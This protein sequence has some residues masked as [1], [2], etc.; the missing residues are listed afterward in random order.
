[1]MG[2][3]LAVGLLAGACSGSDE[4]ASP[5][6][7]TPGV[8]V[9]EPGSEYVATIRRTSFGIPHIVAADYA[10]LGFGQG[11]ALAEDHACTLADQ[12]VKVRGERS[13]FFGA[14]TDDANLESDLAY[15]SLD[16]VGR[17]GAILPTLD[18][19]VVDAITGYAAG[20]DAWLAEVGV[21]GVPGWCQGEDWVR[22]ITPAELFAYLKDL[23]LLASSRNLITPI[24]T[25]APPA[26]AP[27]TPDLT[28]VPA[29]FGGAPDPAT[30]GSNGWAIGAEGTGTD[31]GMLVANPHFP[32]EGE[33]RLWEN[34]LTIP[35]RLDVYGAS[36]IGT[37]GVLIGFNENVAWTHT[38][39]AGARFT[40]Y[41][42]DLVPG[43]P[44]S[45]R[46]GAETRKMTST[47]ISVP[48]R[49][50]DGTTTDVT[51][52]MWSS[53]YGPMINFP[54]VG[55]TDTLALTYR[56]AALGDDGF[57][58]QFLE[59]DRAESLD[60][61]QAAFSE[62]DGTPWVNTMAVGA[63]GTA[64]YAD[65]SATP[66]LSP[67]A[68]AAYVASLETDALVGAAA[69]QRAVLLDGSDPMFEWVDVPGAPGPG[70]T[71]FDQ[72]PSLERADFVANANDP[73]WIANPAE[74]LTGAS[75]LYG[76]TDKPLSARTRENFIV[77]EELTGGAGRVDVEGAEQ[78]GAGEGGSI[79]TF[80]A[81]RHAVLANRSSTATLLQEA[82]AERCTAQP[83][84]RVPALVDDGGAEVWPAQ[85]VDL[86]DA[87]AVL[88]GW[89]GTFDLESIGAALWREFLA[90]FTP[91][92]RADAGIL[93]ANPFDP[94]DPIATPNGLADSATAEDGS[95]PVLVRLG[96]AVL[97]LDAAGVAIDAPLRE[98]QFA[99]RGEERIPIHGGREADGTTNQVG[100][101]RFSTTL[102]PYTTRP[103]LAA[104]GGSIT[105]DGYPV[106]NGSSF[107]MVFEFT[108]EGP[109][110][111]ALLTYGQSGDVESPYFAD[112]TYRFSD[113]AWRPVLF[114][115]DQVLDDPNL[116]EQVVRAPR[117]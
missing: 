75:P 11:Y 59:M 6:D 93:W 48:V 45:Y 91:E 99:T 50:D 61:F 105:T 51:R 44:T 84:V 62:I 22:P 114:T 24:A 7:T 103:P 107:V 4:A 55:W 94:A 78:A 19:D 23:T 57:L 104:D 5:G 82:V 113:K 60:D 38:V 16:L 31:Y 110:A 2:L 66:N 18:P 28:V 33:L 10:S 67:E 26:A 111:E 41:K 77:L 21:D 54:G 30:M 101:S 17:A 102:E 40:A 46:Y 74:P 117:S 32:W 12:I 47:D 79:L 72:A 49:A 35:G 25:A 81:L 58:Q 112:Q 70:L 36:L 85:T 100:Y 88:D 108:D 71:P 43:D 8:T 20:Y 92:E 69:K 96:Q 14:G 87:C 97:T 106:N 13:S 83:S 1:M 65:G 64:W 68:Q 86:T 27:A 42:L 52:T 90:R 95:D 56:D 34:Q 76:L 9:G 15:R 73:Y 80:D 98:A 109:R 115:D 39:S 3:T 29:S 63:D 53:H 37:P 89:L 116:E